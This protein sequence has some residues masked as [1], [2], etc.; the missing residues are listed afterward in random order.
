MRV[1]ELTA[2]CEDGT[3]VKEFNCNCQV[4]SVDDVDVISQVG[5][6]VGLP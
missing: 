4:L 1:C 2:E 5:K 6:L 3:P